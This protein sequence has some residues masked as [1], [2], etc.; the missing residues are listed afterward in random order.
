MSG[1]CSIS[2]S[3]NRTT[4]QRHHRHRRRARH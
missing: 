1:C 2:R 3:C 4:S